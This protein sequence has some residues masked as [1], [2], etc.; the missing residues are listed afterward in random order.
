[1]AR[2]EGFHYTDLINEILCLAVDRYALDDKGNGRS[3]VFP[4]LPLDAWLSVLA[5]EE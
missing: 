3:R 2:A 1:M 5:E 4:D